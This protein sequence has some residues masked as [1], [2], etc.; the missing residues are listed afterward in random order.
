LECGVAPNDRRVK[1]NDGV[2]IAKLEPKA[3]CR[4]EF[5]PALNCALPGTS[6]FLAAREPMTFSRIFSF[7]RQ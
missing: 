1:I 7:E 5:F 6:N 3:Q 2:I 4:K